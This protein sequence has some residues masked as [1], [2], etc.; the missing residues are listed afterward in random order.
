[1]PHEKKSGKWRRPCRVLPARRYGLYSVHIL[2]ARYKTDF[3]VPQGRHGGA[4]TTKKKV[5]ACRVTRC[6]VWTGHATV[7][8]RPFSVDAAAQCGTEKKDM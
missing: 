3:M 5:V 4:S 1:M 2:C 8:H 6:Y 7:E